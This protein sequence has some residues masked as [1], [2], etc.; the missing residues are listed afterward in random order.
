MTRLRQFFQLDSAERRLILQCACLLAAM[1]VGLWIMS[2]RRLQALVI[3]GARRREAALSGARPSVERI[4]RAVRAAARYVPG[5]T[6][7]P[8]AL[9]AEFVLMRHGYPARVRIG[10]ARTEDRALEGHAWVESGGAVVAGGG[11]VGRFTPVPVLGNRGGT[12]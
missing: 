11:D 4:A 2:V 6:C 5:A 9:T 1:R 10:M 3:R 7:L 8:Q 12:E